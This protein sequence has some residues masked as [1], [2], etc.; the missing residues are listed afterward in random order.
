MAQTGCDEESGVDCSGLVVPELNHGE[1]GRLVH[2][3]A[4]EHLT[5]LHGD[6]G[7][8]VRLQSGIQE[9][10]SVEFINALLVPEIDGES[11]ANVARAS[12]S[13]IGEQALLLHSATELL[14]GARLRLSILFLNKVRDA[15][16]EVQYLIC[17][18]LVVV[19]ELHE[20]KAL[21]VLCHIT[22]THHGDI[23]LFGIR[24]VGVDCL[25]CLPC[26]R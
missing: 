20:I 11:S 9:E 23:L 26:S 1:E 19:V 22:E 13:G 7:R 6:G 4:Q 12:F 24:T 17:I 5:N 21:G 2:V 18:A 10:R 15:V 16:C 3:S 8:C 14:Q 25:K